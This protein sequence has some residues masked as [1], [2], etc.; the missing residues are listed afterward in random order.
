MHNRNGL[1]PR[2]YAHVLY[3]QIKTFG[4]LVFLKQ[5][6]IISIDTLLYSRIFNLG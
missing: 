3:Y 6:L 5:K 4:S 2:M 1:V